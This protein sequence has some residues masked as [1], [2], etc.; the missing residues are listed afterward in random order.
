MKEF[1]TAKHLNTIWKAAKNLFAASKTVEELLNM[2][3]TTEMDSDVF[4]VTDKESKVLMA[5][6]DDGRAEFPVGTCAGS[7]EVRGDQMIGGNQ[8]VEG[9]VMIRDVK[10]IEGVESGFFYIVD[11]DNYILFEINHL[12]KADFAGIPRDVQTALDALSERVKTLEE[13]IN[14]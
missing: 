7:S 10:L 8:R 1:A 11:K 9:N 3:R 4:A 12:G 2:F 13:N 6:N 14:N 5:I